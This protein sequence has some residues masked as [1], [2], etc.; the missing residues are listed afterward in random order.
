MKKILY[1][2]AFA[3]LPLFAFAQENLQQKVRQMLND[4]T[5]KDTYERWTAAFDTV[6]SYFYDLPY[7]ECFQLSDEILLPFAEKNIK[8]LSKRNIAKA[9][10]CNMVYL[11][12][13]NRGLPEDTKIAGDVLKEG[14]EFAERS[15]DIAICALLFRQYAYFLSQMG[16]ISLAHE[17][18]YKS[19]SLY[20]SLKKYKIVSYCL[21]CIAH[22]LIQA[23][24]IE[25]L[26]KL[27]EQVKLNINKQTDSD[28]SNSWFDFYLIQGTYYLFLS[29]DYPEI[30]AYKDSAFVACSNAINLWENNE[31]ISQTDV[32]AY[33]YF[34]MA[35]SYHALYPNLYDSI[36]YFL[37]KAHDFMI[38]ERVFDTGLEIDVYLLYANLHFEQ[39][40]YVQAEKDIFHVLSLLE[41]ITD[42]NQFVSRYS[43]AYKFLVM[44]YETTN[45]PAEAIKYYKLLLENEQKRYNNEKIVAMD[46]MLVKYEV[47]KKNEQLDRMAERAQATRKTLL[48]SGVLI[49]VLMITLIILI[50]FYKLR[51]QRLE[52]SV[53]ES[54]LLAELKQNELDAERQRIKQHL[55]QKPTKA[56]IEKLMEWILQSPI[57]KTKEKT[58][59]RQLSELDIDMLEQG[60][61][62]ADEKI[63]NME[64]KY[65]ICFAID[66]D[67]KDMG[68]LFN[69]E[70]ASIRTVRYRIKKK[71]GEKNSFKFLM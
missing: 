3:F 49:A 31:K 22:D 2:I 52:Q 34:N 55:E 10:I 12:Y 41:A 43:N 37:D 67:V 62:S 60:Y 57:D 30:T 71:F 51:K 13:R 5:I 16:N 54:A 53:Y 8:D 45:R 29:L 32:G 64:M 18:Y 70:P 69:V 65:I 21:S 50:R 27:L 42:Y 24:N 59:I 28:N 44:F 58:Y 39:K 20:E 66:M 6:A 38:N 33:P 15:N 36:Y 63:S 26:R 35:L 47:E 23:R 56:I 7:D 14:V 19:I 61:L 48:L 68:L 17:Y 9:Y 11:T 25:G 4:K 46:D 40:K 1:L